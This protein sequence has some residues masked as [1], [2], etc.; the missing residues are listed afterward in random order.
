MKI[1]LSAEA[2]KRLRPNKRTGKAA[3]LRGELKPKRRA[4]VPALGMTVEEGQE[5]EVTT[6]E[7]A[8]LCLSGLM[9]P[10][11]AEAKAAVKEAAEKAAEEAKATEA[12]TEEEEPAKPAKGS[13][14]G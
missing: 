14:E 1:K 8:A 3:E 2:L 10:V 13:K 11:D 6:E 12:D 7:A 5:L 9:A 4:E